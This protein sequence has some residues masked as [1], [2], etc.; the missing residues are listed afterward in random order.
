MPG[1]GEGRAGRHTH[2]LEVESSLE[3]T[4][5]LAAGTA[6]ETDGD[7]LLL[8]EDEGGG[9]DQLTLGATKVLVK[10]EERGKR[11]TEGEGDLGF[12]R[13]AISQP[14]QVILMPTF[15]RTTAN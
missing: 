2:G 3:E 12:S 8:L 7:V 6:L 15:S 10:S 11:P 9:L 14:V 1:E 5:V 13:E 4:S